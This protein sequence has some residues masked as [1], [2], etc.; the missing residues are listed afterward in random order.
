MNGNAE[1]L[2]FIYQNSEMGTN[3][4]KQLIQIVE[5]KD[6]LVYLETQLKGYQ[7][8]EEKAKQLLNENGCDEKG[9]STMEKIRTYFM[10]N[11]KTLTDKSASNIA[12]MMIVGSTM[13][14]IDATRQLNRYKEAEKNIRNLMEDLL[15]FEEKNVE[16]LKKF[17]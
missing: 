11:M 6:F 2:N 16:K 17:L 12:E 13:G 8:V 10:I 14:I 7:D 4:L 9:I 5:E 1:L 3:T 15:S